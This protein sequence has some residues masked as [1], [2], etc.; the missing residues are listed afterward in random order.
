MRIR[1]LIKEKKKEKEKKYSFTNLTFSVGSLP[2]GFVDVDVSRQSEIRDFTDFS[3]SEENIPGREVS[4]YQLYNW[5][6]H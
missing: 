6:S 1:T 2:V 4:V 5:S 3:V